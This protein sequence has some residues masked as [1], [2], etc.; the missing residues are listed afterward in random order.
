MVLRLRDRYVY[1]SVTEGFERFRKQV[2]KS[3]FQKPNFEANF[4]KTE[5]FLKKWTFA[6]EYFIFKKA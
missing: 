1:V 2:F 6:T 4:L 5:S 3:N